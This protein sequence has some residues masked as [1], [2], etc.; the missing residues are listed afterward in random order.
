M[1]QQSIARRGR[2]EEQPGRVISE[3]TRRDIFDA[4]RLGQVS[5]SGR[6]SESGFL[7]RV[8][9]LETLP[10]MDY[11]CST[12]LGDVRLHRENFSDWGGED[13]VYD[14]GRLDLLRCADEVVL[15]FL[16]EMIHPVVRPDDAEADKLLELFNLHL[17]ADGYQI[18]VKAMISGKRIF[19]GVTAIHP[20]G[21]VTFDA[22]KVA[23]SLASDH[24]AAQITRMESSI[25]SDPGLAIGSAKEFVE[26]ICKGILREHSVLPSGAEDLPK[27]VRMTREAVGLL[28]D[29][30]TD[31]TLKR[32]LSALATITQGL[33]ELRGQL[34]T[35][36]GADPAAPRPPAD[37]AGLAVRM[38]TALGIFLYE[39]HRNSAPVPTGEI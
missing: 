5:W 9:D 23:D 30:R 35:G 10:S 8:F 1:I 28:T 11:R 19:A 22:R 20:G 34:G 21:A 29:S 27:L 31:E 17:A 7:T 26:S 33:A 37:V 15:R 13:W 12:M 2:L 36:H 24:V 4:L 3:V 14:D 18:A 38:A 16:C 25:V 39:K 6:L 32:T